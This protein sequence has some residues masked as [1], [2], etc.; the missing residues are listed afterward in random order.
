MDAAVLLSELYESTDARTS[1]RYLKIAHAIRDSL[2]SSGKLKETQALSYAEKER[3]NEIALAETAY[4]NRIRQIALASGIGLLALLSI[5]LF[6][7]NRTKQKANKA[8]QEQKLK[9]E[10]AL[11]RLKLTQ[12]QL[13][14][15]EKMA[16]LGELTAGIAH[17]IQ[18]PLNFVNNFSEINSDLI[19]DLQDA[20]AKGD[21]Q[22]AA[23]TA[24]N[25]K[26]NE[27]K[28]QVHGK[29][30]DDIVKSM[31][32]HSHGSGMQKEPREVNGLVEEY[33]RVAYHGFR[34]RYKDFGVEFDINPVPK[35]GAVHLVPQ[36]IGR[37]VVNLLNNAFYAVQEKAKTGGPDYKPKVSAQAFIQKLEGK[38]GSRN[39]SIF[40]EIADNGN[41][42]PMQIRDKI[43]NPFFTTKPTGQGT[44]LGLSL[45]Y[46][47]VKA[48]GG[49]IEL[50]SSEGKGSLFRIVLPG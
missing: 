21:V 5:G 9:V 38:P 39:E 26:E 27:A 29:R 22:L 2:Y 12:A 15:S 37:V 48:H 44:G 7:N 43:F 13:I 49:T 19:E 31:L 10:E 17:E 34:A 4:R 30:A 20:L 42:I 45:S 16:S 50:E 11:T 36:E 6:R 24:Q 1:L 32:Q 8:L 47:L 25:L 40:I 18:N 28:I 35:T 46:D 14:Q 3:Q 41:G 23:G 33:A